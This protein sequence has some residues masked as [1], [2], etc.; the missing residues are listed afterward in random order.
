MVCLKN[1]FRN[2]IGN[3]EHLGHILSFTPT[4]TIGGL[5]P[6]KEI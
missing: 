1:S 4:V 5:L 3:D 2:V 6:S